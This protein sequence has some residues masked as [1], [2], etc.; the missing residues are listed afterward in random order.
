KV[1]PGPGPVLVRVRRL[2]DGPPGIRLVR[3]ETRLGDKPAAMNLM[4]ESDERLAITLE[5]VPSEP[6]TMT[7]PP[8]S[9]AELV[10][11]Q[12]SDRERDPVFR[13]SMAVARILAETL[14]SY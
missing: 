3:L 14:F 11:R 10:G 1:G 2:A 4:R 5:G 8:Q 9:P 13:D 6:R 7:V 12:L